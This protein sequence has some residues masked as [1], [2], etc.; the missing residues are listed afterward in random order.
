MYKIVGTRV[1][2]L[3]G[4]GAG[5]DDTY[6]ADPL[7]INVFFFFFSLSSCEICRGFTLAGWAICGQFASGKTG[8]K[9]F[10]LSF[11]SAQEAGLLV[12]VFLQPPT[13]PVRVASIC[14]S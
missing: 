8:A 2:V 7:R 6:D 14:S 3:G 13:W 4:G 12:F 10:S 1:A 11:Q 5:R 9:W